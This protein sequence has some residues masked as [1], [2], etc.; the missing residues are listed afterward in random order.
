[1]R[2]SYSDF[3]LSEDNKGPQTPHQTS[4]VAGSLELHSIADQ[5][6]LSRT[7]IYFNQ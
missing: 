7:M 2:A 1:M 3:T 5:Q 6:G 4:P